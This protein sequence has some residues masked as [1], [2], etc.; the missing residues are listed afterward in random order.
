MSISTGITAVI[1]AYNEAGRI[2]ETVRAVALYVD[3]VLVVDDD[4]TDKTAAEAR[5]AGARVIRQKQNR[6]YIAAIKRGFSEAIG[7]II[8]TIDADGEF[9]PEQIPTL[10]QPILN[11]EADMVQG[12]R[13][14]IPRPSERF[15]T[16]LANFRAPVGDSGTGFRAI[17]AETARQLTLKGACICGIFSLEV[18]ARGGRLEEVPVHLQAIGKPRRI[19]WYH[20]QQFFFLLPWLLRKR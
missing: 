4:S 15:L 5:Q 11:D 9:P 1:P 7:E 13:D 6:G 8:V 20:L 10:V 3:E 14:S 2:G 16:W 12:H 17:R 19:A 18:L